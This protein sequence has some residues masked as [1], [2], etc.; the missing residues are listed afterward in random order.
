[1]LCLVFWLT[2]LFCVY[3]V[4]FVGPLFSFPCSCLFFLA[5]LSSMYFF[6][7]LLGW[8]VCACVCVCVCVCVCARMC[9]CVRVCLWLW[10]ALVG[11]CCCACVCARARVC[12]C[13]YGVGVDDWVMWWWWWTQQ[14]SMR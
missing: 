8:F 10:F 1:F 6:L 2:F 4:L 7:W 14:R 13:V 12:M 11:V 3:S 5:F 9:V